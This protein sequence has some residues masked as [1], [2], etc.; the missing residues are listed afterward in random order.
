MSRVNLEAERS[1]LQAQLKHNA[2]T[3]SALRSQIGK[4]LGLIKAHNPKLFKAV[5][6]ELSKIKR[7]LQD[8]QY[9]PIA[10]A[11]LSL[12]VFKE[13]LNYTNS[14]LLTIPEPDKVTAKTPRIFRRR[15]APPRMTV[16]RITGTTAGEAAP[17]PAEPTRGMTPDADSFNFN[18]DDALSDSAEGQA[19]PR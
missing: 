10:T 12:K 11:D 13:A 15:V 4:N 16:T 3:I 5:T 9:T 2:E 1:R 19:Y 17:T 7:R 14:I 18:F 6:I 8:N